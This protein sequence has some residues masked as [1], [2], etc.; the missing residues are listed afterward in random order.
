MTFSLPRCPH[1]SL[2][3][4]FSKILIVKRVLVMAELNEENA[5]L[6]VWYGP[7]N[8]GVAEFVIG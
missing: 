6:W 3:Y 8:L 4:Q 5:G 1:N 7:G 2:P